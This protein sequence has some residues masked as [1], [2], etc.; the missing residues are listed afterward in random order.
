MIKMFTQALTLST[1]FP[2]LSP[3]QIALI[4]PLIEI[5]SYQK[6]TVIFEQGDVAQY[7]YIVTGGEVLVRYKAYDGP[8]ITVAR[9][10]SGSVFG[11]SAALG[12]AT[13]TSGAVCTEDTD[14]FRISGRSLRR[15]CEQHPET[16]VVVLER[17]AG[18]TDERLRTTHNQILAMLTESTDPKGECLRRKSENGGQ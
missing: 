9:V 11:W 8:L 18:M 4:Q 16:G 5:C 1:I 2:N 6:D 12:R 10:G 7:I 14:T 3:E 17:L 15:I 13:Y